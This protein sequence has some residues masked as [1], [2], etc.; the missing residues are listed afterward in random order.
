MSAP[1]RGK[2][3]IVEAKLN[4]LRCWSANRSVRALRKGAVCGI[5]LGAL[6]D[7]DRA[8]EVGAVFD[9]D[10]GGREIAVDGAILLDFDAVF[11]TEIAFHVAIDHDF[12]SDDV[13]G[14]LRGSAN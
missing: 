7:F 6:I 14:Q 3:K 12:A 2:N 4:R 11:G 1:P 9:H 5:L 10:A 8:F 13:G